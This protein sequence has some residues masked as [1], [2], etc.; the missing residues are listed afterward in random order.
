[1]P[2]TRVF[3]AIMSVC[4]AGACSGPP[5]GSDGI[6]DPHEASNRRVHAFNASLDDKL[7]RR[8]GAGYARSVPPDV[9]QVVGNMADTVSLPQTVV[10]QILQGR[11]GRA[12]RNT[13]RFSINATLG[14]AGMFDVAGDFGLRHDESDF[15]ETL[16]VWG[17]PEGAYLVLPIAGPSTKRDAA[18]RVVDLF[19]NPLDRVLRTPHRRAKTGILMFDR[20]GKRGRYG[21][22]VDGILHD[23]ADSYAQLRLIYLQNRR[24]ALGIAPPSGEEIDPTEIDVTGF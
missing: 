14:I 11:L 24:H 16:A 12:T 23:S 15:G 9:Q 13:L 10:N 3:L 8:A 2:L 21:A 1:M 4:L 7:T 22:T 17:V 6:W 20:V 5:P 18:G 19:T